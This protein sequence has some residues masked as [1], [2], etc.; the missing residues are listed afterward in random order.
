MDNPFSD[1]YHVP[2]SQELLDIA[3]KRAMKSS[4]QVSKNAPI[5][6]KAK[7]KEHRRIKVAVDEIINRIQI[8]IKRVPMIE[9]L[10]DFYKELASLIVDV[11]ELRLTLGKLNGILPI[12]NQ[13]ERDSLRQLTRIETPKEA[14]RIRRAAFGRI[15]SIINKQNPNLEYLNEIRGDLRTIPSLDYTSPCVV[16]AGYPNVGKSSIV[17]LV[18]T[19]KKIEVQEY[20]FTTKELNLGHLEIQRRFD[21]YKIQLMDTPGILDRPMP[22]RNKIELKAILALRVISDLIIFV[23]DPTPAC[24]YSID[25]QI[26]LYHEVHQN[27]EKEGSTKIFIVINK[28]DLAS[29]EEI[30]YIT[31]KLGLEEKDY[32]LTNALTG[33][34]IDKIISYLQKNYSPEI[35]YEI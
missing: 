7:K 27:F 5:L 20:P 9:E 33:E 25:S 11:D 3:F 15:S 1:F 22:R 16:V 30:K 13:I 35:E 18:S 23:F 21:S 4:A 17:K 34:N 29:N 12:L 6:I 26:E 24:G 19:N 31:D 8:V 14:D 10:P 28:M 32:I 2:N